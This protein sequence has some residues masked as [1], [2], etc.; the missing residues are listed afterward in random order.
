M[1]CPTCKGSAGACGD[2]DCA[3]IYGPPFLPGLVL[4]RIQV[5]LGKHPELDRLGF[6]RDRPHPTK[7]PH[8]LVPPTCPEC[9]YPAKEK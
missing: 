3:L 7:C 6:S 8:D 4:L 5:A 9:H 2:D 1:R